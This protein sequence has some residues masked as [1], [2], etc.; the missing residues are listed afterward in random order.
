MGEKKAV[1]VRS[2]LQQMTKDKFLLL[3]LFGVLL[4]VIAWPVEQKSSKSISNTGWENE[5][6]GGE[7]F[8][9]G[10]GQTEYAENAGRSTDAMRI[11]A[12]ELEQALE[13][14]LFTMDGVGKVKV[15][16]TVEDCGKAVVEKDSSN[17]RSGSTEVD[18]AGGS[19]NTTDITDTETTVYTGGR[20]GNGIPY[21][22]RMLAPEIAGVLV[23]AQGGGEDS[24]VRNITDAI[25]AL[26][27][28]PSH[29][30]K[31]VKMIS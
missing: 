14:V 9:Q 7:D 15:M 27:G 21:V 23:S 11:Y 1:S 5:E 24:V 12:K 17:T 25:Q 4:L 19:R 10:S 28:I 26:F 29:K 2:K 6:T 18:S 13:E 8:T 30:I 22:T 31:I 16:I 20:S 3:L